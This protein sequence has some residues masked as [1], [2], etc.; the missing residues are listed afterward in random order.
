MNSPLQEINRYD[1]CKFQIVFLNDKPN[2]KE[3]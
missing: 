2:A 3:H 1:N